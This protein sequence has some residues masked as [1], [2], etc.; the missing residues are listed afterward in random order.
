M[1]D[2]WDR[3]CLS[4]KGVST[5]RFRL[6]LFRRKLR[7]S[8]AQP[9]ADQTL[10]WPGKSIATAEQTSLPEM[11]LPRAHEAVAGRWRADMVWCWAGRA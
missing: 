3:G 9:R 5:L 7:L 1:T 6:R 2:R 4:M 11:N 10:C 8:R